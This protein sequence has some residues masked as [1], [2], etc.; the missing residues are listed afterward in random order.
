M[1]EATKPT[2]PPYGYTVDDYN[3]HYR[4]TAIGYASRFENPIITNKNGHTYTLQELKD[5]VLG[6]TKIQ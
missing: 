5:N 4:A 2:A 6:P 3:C 1:S